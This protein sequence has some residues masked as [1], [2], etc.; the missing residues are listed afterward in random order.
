MTPSPSANA[1]TSPGV[2]GFKECQ[3][4][5]KT[6]FAPAFYLTKSSF[7]RIMIAKSRAVIASGN[8]IPRLTER[9]WLFFIFTHS[10]ACSKH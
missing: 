4:F 1:A 2:R 3:L 9:S 6:Q 7:L 5:R 10:S 8:C